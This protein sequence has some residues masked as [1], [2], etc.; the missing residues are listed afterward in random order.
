[1]AVDDPVTAHRVHDGKIAPPINVGMSGGPPL[2]TESAQWNIRPL[3]F[4]GPFRGSSCDTL[5]HRLEVPERL[6]RKL[7]V[8]D[9]HEIEIALVGFEVA[10]G[11]RAV[12]THT[13]EA[14]AENG[15]HSR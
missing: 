9:H 13:D 12:K 6:G 7:T 15:S 5:M 10:T 8:S 2:V 4:F 1:M 3:Q 11:E 14:M